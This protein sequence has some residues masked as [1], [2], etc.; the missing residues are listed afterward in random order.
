MFSWIQYVGT[1]AV[2]KQWPAL[3]VLR[4]NFTFSH[5]YLILLYTMLLQLS[6]RHQG[7]V[8]CQ[9]AYLKWY[10]LLRGC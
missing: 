2:F 6:T 7:A 5:D 8:Q 10:M 3:L 1:Y 4:D 9:T